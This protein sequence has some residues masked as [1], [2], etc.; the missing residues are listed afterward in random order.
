VIWGA[1]WRRCEGRG[2]EGCVEGWG[3]GEDMASTLRIGGVRSHAVGFEAKSSCSGGKG[4]SGFQSSVSFRG[5]SLS[6]AV[7]KASKRPGEK[8][9]VGAAR[10]A[11]MQAASLPMRSHET[12]MRFFFSFAIQFN[13][14]SGFF[15]TQL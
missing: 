9:G 5:R 15:L 3:S 4:D 7:A 12:K 6:N 10:A 8:H 11:L 13:C 2:E 1:G 14:F